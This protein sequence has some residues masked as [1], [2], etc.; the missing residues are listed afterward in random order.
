M[1]VDH[2]NTVRCFQDICTS[3]VTRW[4][5]VIT[6]SVGDEILALFG[7]PRNHKDD[8]ERAVHAGLDLVAR[9][10]EL[11]SPSGEPLQVRSAIAT[12]LVL[13]CENWIAIGE[14]IVVAGQLG[15]ITPPNSVT[16][17]ASTRKLLG[18]VYVCDDPQR[19]ELEGVSE[20]VTC[21]RVTGKR[22]LQSRF[23]AKS[24]GKH[25]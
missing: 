21:Y 17:S 20:P 8:A 5:G 18:S 25:I 10:G 2:G 16:V 22:T 1:G 6:H 24:C 15:T 7:Y 9:V 13:I 12:G 3:V 23:D 11:L 14:A 4:G 19:R